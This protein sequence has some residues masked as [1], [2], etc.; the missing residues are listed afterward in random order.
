MLPKVIGICG[1]K[2]CGKD[3]LARYFVDHHGYKHCKIADDL[4]KVV[5]VLFGFTD[6]QLETDEKDQV[7]PSWNITPRSAMQFFGTEVMQYK[8]QE[9]LPD[10]QRNFWIM[11]FIKKHLHTQPIVISD[12]RFLHEYDALMKASQSNM[13][14][15]RVE[16]DSCVN[17]SHASEQ[18]HK[19]IP[20]N[21]V[22]H[23]NGNIEELYVELKKK[24]VELD[25]TLTA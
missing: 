3:T 20:A 25:Y 15:I 10:V 18:E 17:C 19:D 12:L 9:I 23:N 5:Q 2:R 22:I 13:L 24:L 21:M 14:V 11:S 8:I 4:K 16:R 1:L 7:D 6:G